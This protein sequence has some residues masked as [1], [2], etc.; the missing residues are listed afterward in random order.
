MTGEL[1]IDNSFISLIQYCLKPYHFI[2]H[3]TR[4]FSWRLPL[5]IR[6][7]KTIQ[8]SCISLDTP[9]L[10]HFWIQKYTW[11]TCP[12]QSKQTNRKCIWLWWS[13]NFK[14]F[15]A[16]CEYPGFFIIEFSFDSWDFLECVWYLRMPKGHLIEKELPISEMFGAWNSV[17]KWCFKPQLLVSCF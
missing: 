5:S 7:T 3:S 1:S 8:A 16:M 9:I 14:I 4:S 13:K 11:S 15:W 2:R 17:C 12:F 10:S 6:L